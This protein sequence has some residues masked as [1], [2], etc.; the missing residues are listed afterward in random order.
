MLGRTTKIV[1]TMLMLGAAVACSDSDSI[2]VE[3]DARIRV[4]L[5]D[6]PADYIGSAMVD[7][8]AVEL[9]PA[10]NGERIVL[11]NDGTDGLV[12]LMELQNEA[13]LA[14]ADETIPSGSYAQLRMI[15]EAATVTLADGFTFNDGSTEQDLFVPSGAQTGIKLN[16]TEGDGDGES[17]PVE[18]A[19]GETVLV[20]DFD[21]NQSFVIQGD[22]NTP[23]GINSALF[24]PTIR[25]VVED[26]AGAISGT[27]TT[28]TEQSVEGLVVTAEP[29]GEGVLEEFQT[30]T[31]TA[32]TDADGLYTIHFVVPGPYT[33]SVEVPDGFA[34]EP[35]AQPADVG[36][37]AEVT[38]VD[39]EI[40]PSS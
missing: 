20:L 18:I 5:T 15:V 21:V 7:I 2:A 40:V 27:V 33:V 32:M 24:T 23:A 8:G 4:L 34:A 28:S 39:F 25:V 26:V 36:E 19:G 37:G 13:T 17:G 30:A 10:D 3:D 22:P 29:A 1:T 11:S 16:L 35:D 9:L 38:G 12:D 6:A 14:L 31:A